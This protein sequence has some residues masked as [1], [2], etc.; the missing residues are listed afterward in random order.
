M[1]DIDRVL[2]KI[3]EEPTDTD[4]ITI[5]A[6]VWARVDQQRP[7]AETRLSGLARPA[8]ILANPATAIVSAL[9]IG[10]LIG[11]SSLH[12]QSQL[13]PMST[14]SASAPYAPSTLLGAAPR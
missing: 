4:L 13:G 9:L 7:P 2:K 11:A 10:V 6:E 14:F 3:A 1:T 8:Q 12:T 5:E